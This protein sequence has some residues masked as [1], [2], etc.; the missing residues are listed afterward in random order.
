MLAKQLKKFCTV[1]LSFQCVMSHLNLTNA[2]G[3][4]LYVNNKLQYTVRH[5]L[6]LPIGVI[7]N[8]VPLLKARLLAWRP[9]TLF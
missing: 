4:G 3:V 8:H 7:I 1:T 9:S 6:E 5:D 2:G